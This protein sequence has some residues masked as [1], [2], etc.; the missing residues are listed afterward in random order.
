MIRKVHP[1]S[2][3]C[4]YRRMSIPKDAVER[5]RR[6]QKTAIVMTIVFA[7]I[8]LSVILSY[9]WGAPSPRFRPDAGIIILFGI[10]VAA[11]VY[12]AARY[13]SEIPFRTRQCTPCGRGIPL[14]AVFCPY[15]GIRL[16][17]L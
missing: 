12:I 16:P 3:W 15:C 14:D 2:V 1:N 9:E 5:Q 10:L 11:I 4:C 17:S 7:I 6:E 13:R 8:Q